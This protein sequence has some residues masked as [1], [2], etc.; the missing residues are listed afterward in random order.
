MD[1]FCTEKIM[2]LIPKC[3][4][5]FRQNHRIRD[6]L[7]NIVIALK[8]DKNLIT[9]IAQGKVK[10][11]QSIVKHACTVRGPVPKPIFNEST[12]TCGITY[13]IDTYKDKCKYC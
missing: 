9:D 7:S 11:G 10:A 2:S 3:V 6:Y 5:S 13:V 4:I 8:I 12:G 1:S